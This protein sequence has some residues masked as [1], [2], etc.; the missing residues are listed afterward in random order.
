MIPRLTDDDRDTITVT[1]D[2]EQLQSWHYRN[3]EERR[4]KMRWAR[5]FVEGYYL[6]SQRLAK[7][8]A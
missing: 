8:V 4:Q 7:A 1:I 5:W 3:E 2:G 6:C